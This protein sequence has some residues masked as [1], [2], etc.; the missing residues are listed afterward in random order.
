MKAALAK[1]QKATKGPHPLVQQV[2]NYGYGETLGVERVASLFHTFLEAKDVASIGSGAAG[3]NEFIDF[4]EMVQRGGSMLPENSD[5]EGDNAYDDHYERPDAEEIV[6][7]ADTTDHEVECDDGEAASLAESASEGEEAPEDADDAED[8]IESSDADEVDDD[9]ETPA[10]AKRQ[11]VLPKALQA[12]AAGKSANRGPGLASTSGRQSGGREPGNIMSYFS[13]MPA[14]S[15]SASATASKSQPQHRTQLHLQR[16]NPLAALL[17]QPAPRP[18]NAPQTAE[19]KAM[20]DLDFANLKVFGNASFRHQQRQVITAVLQEQD[21]F[22]LMPTGGGKSLC[23]Q[24]PA[25]L[26]KG[27]T[28]VIS[29]LLSLM[30][31]QVQALC[32]MACGGI[33]ATYLSSQQSK[34]EAL[35]VYRELRKPVPTCKL[36]YLTPE[37]FAKSAALKEVLA[38]LAQR[39]LLARLVVD[40]AHCVSTWGHDFRPDYKELGKIKAASFPGVPTMAL[41]ATATQKVQEDITKILKLQRCRRFQV[42]F[43]RS[44]LVLRVVEKEYGMTDEGKPKHMEALIDF[45]RA[46]PKGAS[47]IVYCLSREDTEGVAR[48]L[49]EQ[50]AIPSRHYHAG[51]TPKQRVEAQNKWQSGQVQ[52]V[53][54]TI[55]FGMGIDKPDVRFV[56]H[57]TLAKSLEGYYQEAGRAGRDGLPAECV[58]FYAKRD[59]PR[60]ITL[61]RG[62]GKR[63]SKKSFDTGMELLNQMKAYCTETQRCRHALLVEYFGEPFTMGSCRTQC[64]VCCPALRQAAG[65]AEAEGA[66]GERALM[67]GRQRQSGKPGSGSSR[68]R[69]LAAAGSKALKSAGKGAAGPGAFVSASSMLNN[70]LTK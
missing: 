21:V 55:A 48:Y 6:G 66:D 46:Q 42:S 32:E 59:V 17:K 4:L 44:K 61:L 41:T 28:V 31:D 20:S 25:V 50:G 49:Q 39:G 30:Q 19:E 51:L 37:Q 10:T 9:F 43:Y 22:V 26:S 62:V 2:L 40:E 12:P 69:K 7:L 35:A 38:G 15:A 16:A 13:K 18:A 47:G 1:A 3:I 45:I 23:Y 8:F 5:D 27:V 65:H 64:D 33:P 70:S 67:P 58:L 52:V 60:L 14:G 54:A 53:V 36:L 29:P 68:A 24:L 11:R 56:L 63:K 34:E 57:F